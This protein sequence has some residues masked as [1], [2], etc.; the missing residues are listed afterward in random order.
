MLYYDRNNVIEFLLMILIGKI[1]MKKILGQ[2]ILMKKILMKKIKYGIIEY[3][4]NF[5]RFIK[6]SSNLHNS[7]FKVNFQNI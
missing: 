6:Y 5:K 4:D 2:K 1:L 3:D 7:D